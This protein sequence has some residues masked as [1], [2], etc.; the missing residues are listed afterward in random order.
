MNPGAGMDAQLAAVRGEL[1]QLSK[2]LDA[3][4]DALLPSVPGLFQPGH[5]YAL[6][7]ARFQC[8]TVTTAPD[9][10][11]PVAWGWAT[12]NITSKAPWTH[13]SM[14]ARTYQQWKDS[15]AHDLTTG[16]PLGD[17]QCE[18]A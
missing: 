6:H 9:S 18:P 17:Q 3:A 4:L 14:T 10:T 16:N 7:H 11:E 5:T 1:T 15:G 2:E 8:V 13:R 12:H